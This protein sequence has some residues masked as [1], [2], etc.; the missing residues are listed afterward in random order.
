MKA[1]M[2]GHPRTPHSRGSAPVSLVIALVIGG[3]ALLVL[4]VRSGATDSN[5]PRVP[6]L[7]AQDRLARAEYEAHVLGLE[8]GV[9]ANARRNAIAK[10]VAMLSSPLV[11]PTANLAWNSI[12]PV[13][14][15]EAANFGGVIV[16]PAVDMT[17]RVSAMAVDPNNANN[18]AVGGANGGI[19]LSTDA[20]ANFTQVFDAQSSQAIGALA[21]DVSTNPSTLWAGTGEGNNSVDSYYGQGL[22]K[23]T[24]LG[25][26]WTSVGS[27]DRIAFAKIAVDNSFSPAHIFLATGNGASAGRSDPF[28]N[29]TDRT[30][31]GLYRSTDGGATFSQYASSVFGCTDHGGPCVA[32]DVSVSHNTVVAAI[33]GDNVFFS[34]DAGN[35]WTPASFPGLTLGPGTL[36]ATFRQTVATQGPNT[37]YAMVGDANGVAYLGFFKSTNLGA[38]WTPETV[39]SANLSGTVIDGTSS[40]NFSQSFYDQYLIASQTTPGTVSF[41][42]VGAYISANS[43]ASWTFIGSSGGIHS[44]QH[45][46][47]LNPAET[48]LYIG[49]DG[50]AYSVALNSG[51]AIT[52]LNSQINLGQ[53]QGIGPLPATGAKLI[54]GFQDNGTQIFSGSPAWTFAETGDGGFALYDQKDPNFVYHTFG[55]S[56]GTAFVS[57]SSDGGSNWQSNGPS[58][59]LFNAMNGAGDRGANFYP[60]FASDPG[61]A[62]RILFGGQF[63]YVSTDGMLTWAQQSTS[64]LT[65]GTCASTFCDAGDIEFSPADPTRA[66]AVAMNNNRH[67]FE[68]SNTI[69]ANMNSGA[70]W[71]NVT[72]AFNTAAGA[73]A[74]VNTQITGVTPDPFNA[75]TAY[76]TISGFK[77]S[78]GVN[79]I[80]KTIDFGVNWTDVTGDLP[81]IP[82]L[83][84]LV[85][86]QDLTGQTLLVATD[87]GVFRSINGGI[88][89]TQV[90]PT[91]AG[92]TLPA[93]PVFDI[94]QSNNGLIFIGTHGRGAY[95]LTTSSATPTPTATATGTPTA[96]PTPTATVTPTPTPTA[97]AT[98]ITSPTPTVTLT[99]TAT[100]TPAVVTVTSSGNGSGKPGSTVAGGTF[101][102]ANNTSGTELISSVTIGVS[103]PNLFSSMTLTATIGG[104][105]TVSGP[106]TPTSA[107]SFTFSP[108]LSLPA[109]QSASFA[110]STVI[111]MNPAKNDRPRIQF[112]YAGIISVPGGKGGGSGGFIPLLVGFALLGIGLL[113]ASERKRLTVAAFAALIVV[114]ALGAAGCGGSSGGGTT[115]SFSSTQTVQGAMVTLGGTTQTVGGLPATLGKIKG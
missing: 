44:D 42:G 96:S 111:S 81:D 62:H 17:G 16:P 34:S 104:N 67:G 80:F 98:V 72:A 83:R 49:N 71:S 77:S 64:D 114:V 70:T 74:N 5:A 35:T 103:D 89:W 50:G 40:S 22:F 113:G 7:T 2:A 102:I 9:P 60:P 29:E 25:A 18:V 101:S 108:A 63:V 69:Q 21:F 73:N 12:G 4:A 51:N 11:T 58:T 82:C 84:M 76:V 92:G 30:K 14:M 112:A 100:P 3:A 8:F 94:E 55:S 36:H 65:S 20:G 47:A 26:T 85:D 97:T 78:T 95:Q 33:N 10:S 54:A 28:F 39:P 105:Q 46:A 32:A 1:K 87:I 38:S 15:T 6:M 45:A 79:H 56:G 37:L 106:V 23:S 109:G 43:G 13:P 24:N 66:W 68:I 99:P 59:T 27:F 90:S 19:W 31:Q 107:T 91:T 86:N 88:N 110:L 57:R 61:T 41:G 115:T 48:T 75:L 52:S 93:V 53:I